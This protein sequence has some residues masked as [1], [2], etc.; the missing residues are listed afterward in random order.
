M[1]TRKNITGKTL[2]ALG[3]E[4]GKWFPEAIEHVNKNQLSEVDMLAY[5]EQFLTINFINLS[6]AQK[7]HIK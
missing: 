1:E 4:S 6:P 7:E 2:I 5:L 3:F